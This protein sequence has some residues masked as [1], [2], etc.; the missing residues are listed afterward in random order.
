MIR[1][2]QEGRLPHAINLLGNKGTGNLPFALALAQYIHCQDKTDTDSCG[3]C[4]ACKKNQL[5]QHPDVHFSFPIVASDK[6]HKVSSS[7]YNEFREFVLQTPYGTDEDWIYF[8]N[9]EKQ[10][11]ISAAECRDIIQKLQLRSFE[12]DYKIQIIWYPE[13]IGKQGNIL[14]K[15]IEEPMPNTIILFVTTNIEKILHTI[16]SRVQTFPL[17]KISIDEIKN[18][19]IEKGADES[20]AIRCAQL[21]D[22]NFNEAIKIYQQ[23]DDQILPLTK[24]LLNSI[25]SNNG[26][27]LTNWITEITDT[28]KE[29]QKKFLANFIQLLEFSIRIKQN[30]NHPTYIPDDERKIVE[31]L[32]KKGLNEQKILETNEL[33]TNA[34]YH[35]ERNANT[36][37][38]FHSVYL[39]VQQILVF[40]KKPYKVV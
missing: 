13:Y 11:N 34:I 1:F 10:G 32:I 14:L 9:K 20:T 7:F 12:S 22:G 2:I 19:L 36:K 40:N 21:A 28:S 30:P 3:K 25:Y 38:L 15:L 27:Q 23:A 35:I 33:L 18:S 29:T 4:S 37:I 26:L 8:L 5:M 39:Q 6:S 31:T 16:R 17:K 24:N